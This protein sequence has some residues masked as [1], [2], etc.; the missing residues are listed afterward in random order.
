MPLPSDILLYGLV[1]ISIALGLFVLALV[2][3]YLRIVRRYSQLKEE[4]SK[5]EAEAKLKAE[6]KLE[7]ASKVSEQIIQEA[8]IKASEI[9]KKTETF[10]RETKDAMIAELGKVSTEYIGSYKQALNEAKTE[11]VSVLAGVSKDLKSKALSEVETF[12]GSLQAEIKS[13]QE[14]LRQ[15]VNAGYQK[16]EGE[17]DKYRKVRLQQVDVA[18]FEILREV[19]Q[20]VI[21]KALTLE[22]HEE[23]VIKSLE[24]AKKEN[25]F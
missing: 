25:V 13:S 6:K 18:I 8:R 15:A 4:K 11:T 24:E 21:G 22:E 16:I 14:A 17:I 7:E 10:S 5:L 12:K 20:R 3:S 19:S 23:L 2:V 9:I 1:L